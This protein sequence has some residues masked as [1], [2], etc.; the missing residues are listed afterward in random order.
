[1]SEVLPIIPLHAQIVSPTLIFYKWQGVSKKGDRIRVDTYGPAEVLDVS[2]YPA[3]QVNNVTAA[4]P[5]PSL[6]FVGIQN[7]QLFS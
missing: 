6:R 7:G 5:P 4:R 1:M 2:Q 3:K